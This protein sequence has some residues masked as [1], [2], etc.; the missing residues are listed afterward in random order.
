M[1]LIGLISVPFLIAFAAVL[2]LG[3]ARSWLIAGL[4]LWLAISIYSLV[5]DCPED[6]YEC[7]PVLGVYFASL[8][9]LG[10]VSG[11]GAAKLTRQAL[12]R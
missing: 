1:L 6:A 9:L 5:R 8:G 3:H 2:L 4:A 11:V 7:I 12:A 10:W